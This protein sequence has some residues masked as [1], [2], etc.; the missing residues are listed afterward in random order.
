MV[1]PEH[2]NVLVWAGINRFT[3]DE[4]IYTTTN[5]DPTPDNGVERSY[6]HNIRT[7][8]PGAETAVGQMLTD[9]NAASLASRYGETET[10][11]YTYSRP[12]DCGWSPVEIL[13]AINCFEYQACEVDDWTTSEAK[14]YCDKLRRRIERRLPGA[15]VAPWE[16]TPASTSRMTEDRD[17]RRSIRHSSTPHLVAVDN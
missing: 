3:H 12:V 11:S 5:D 9:A 13:G 1:T 7:L 16:I 8:R 2:I 15:D 10:R 14:Q 17:T 4:A 6:G